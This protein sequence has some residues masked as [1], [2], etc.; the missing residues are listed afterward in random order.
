MRYRDTDDF[1]NP[2]I[3]VKRYWLVIWGVGLV[4]AS[5]SYFV[6]NSVGYF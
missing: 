6:M 2:G 5:H 1:Q 3:P 4:L